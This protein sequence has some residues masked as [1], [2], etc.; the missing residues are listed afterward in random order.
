MNPSAFL[1][2]A[3]VFFDFEVDA[4]EVGEG[5]DFGE[6]E[7]LMLRGELDEEIHIELVYVL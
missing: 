4:L 2:L 3:A 1:Y 7:G 5:F 6:P